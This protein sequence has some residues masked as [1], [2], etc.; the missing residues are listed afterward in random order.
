M[1]SC[2]SLILFANPAEESS[3]D[4]KLLTGWSDALPCYVW[5]LSLGNRQEMN[6]LQG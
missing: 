1:T 3:A 5:G 4:E 2:R 6:S